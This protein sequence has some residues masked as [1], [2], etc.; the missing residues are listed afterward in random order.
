MERISISISEPFCISDANIVPLYFD[1]LTFNETIMNQYLPRLFYELDALKEV[2]DQYR[3]GPW[4]SAAARPTGEPHDLER[5]LKKKR[6]VVL[7]AYG[8]YG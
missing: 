7:A 5:V 4:I 3:I 2:M 6:R 8:I 1:D